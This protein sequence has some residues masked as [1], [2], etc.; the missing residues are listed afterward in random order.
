MKTMLKAMK[1]PKYNIPEDKIHIFEDIIQRYEALGAPSLGNECDEEFCIAMEK[2]LTKEQRFRLFEQNG[3]CKGTAN[4]KERRDF[5]IKHTRKSLAE[6]IEIFNKI[7]GSNVVLNEKD[8]TITVNFA[9][10]HGYY[11][12][13]KEG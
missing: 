13:V 4:D 2:H 11:K 7:Y 9:C 3:A 6:R 1:M 5:L 8:N 10:T 12:Q